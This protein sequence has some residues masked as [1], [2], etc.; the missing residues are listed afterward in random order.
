MSLQSSLSRTTVSQAVLKFNVHRR[1]PAVCRSVV[2]CGVKKQ[3]K[4]KH[5]SSITATGY[6]ERARVARRLSIGKVFDDANGN[7]NDPRGR[8]HKQHNTEPAFHLI[9]PDPA[10]V[11][12][13]LFRIR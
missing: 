3:L 12:W 1:H 5:S 8:R 7:N 2:G 4:Q 6:P 11:K 9:I 13:S 10:R